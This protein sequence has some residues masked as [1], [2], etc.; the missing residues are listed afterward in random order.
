M[1]L[2]AC[3]VI[4]DT[5]ED[6]INDIDDE[7]TGADWRTWKGYYYATFDHGG[8]FDVVMDI[9][10]TM[11]EIY[12]DNED[13]VS[14]ATI[15]LPHETDV[16]LIWDSIRIED[17]DGDGY[18]DVCVVLGQDGA[19][20]EEHDFCWNPETFEFYD[21]FGESVLVTEQ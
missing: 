14:Y 16:D 5:V 11:I 13:Q 2:A 20:S 19:D 9:M 17:Y 21:Y 18:S 8:E 12:Y 15:L 4:V 10:P 7:I 6:E 1:C 3:G